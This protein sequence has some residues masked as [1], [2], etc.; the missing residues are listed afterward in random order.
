MDKAARHIAARLDRRPL[1]I[2][3]PAPFIATLLLLALLPQ[4][5]QLALGKRMARTATEDRTP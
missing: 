1:E 4:R 3:F 2:A 5:L